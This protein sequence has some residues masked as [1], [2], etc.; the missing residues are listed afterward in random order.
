MTFKIDLEIPK[1]RS[2]RLLILKEITKS[3]IRKLYAEDKFLLEKGV[4][5]ISIA[6]KLA[7]CYSHFISG[8]SIDIEY[9]RKG[10]NPEPKILTDFYE[11]F[12]IIEKNKIPE[13]LT[14][15]IKKLFGEETNIKKI[16]QKINKEFTNLKEKINKNK[17]KKIIPDIIIHSR[18]INDN[19]LI[20]IELKKYGK[21]EAIF[22]DIVKLYFLRKD[23]EYKHAVFINFLTKQRKYEAY[24]IIYKKD[25]NIIDFCKEN[26]KL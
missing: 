12:T 26:H 10:L 9:N 18:G 16:T 8:L 19:N 4:K 24:W 13:N 1:K 14:K 17:I 3:A 15:V 21:P 20:A 6:H 25:N 11:I 7:N 5:E 2:S 22:C 23:Y